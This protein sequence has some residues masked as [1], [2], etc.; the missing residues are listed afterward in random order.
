[1][2]KFNVTGGKPGAKI[3]KTFIVDDSDAWIFR[4]Y[5]WTLIKH[6]ATDYWHLRRKIFQSGSG[7]SKKYINEEITVHIIK[8]KNESDVIR[9]VNGNSLDLRRANLQCV[10]RSEFT[11]I[12][13]GLPNKIMQLAEVRK[14]GEKKV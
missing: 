5:V 8:K 2:K 10:S 13:C 1:M 14:I 12:T 3:T 6:D 4:S 9:R 7:A 11:R